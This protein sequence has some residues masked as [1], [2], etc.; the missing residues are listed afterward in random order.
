MRALRLSRYT[1]LGDGSLGIRWEDMKGK[2]ITNKNV[3]LH[4]Y[5]DIHPFRN[6]PVFNC[7]N[8]FIHRCNENFVGY[9]LKNTT[10]PFVKTVF[11]GSH[12]CENYTLIT[13]DGKYFDR[14]I[15]SKFDNIYLHEKYAR[16]KHRWW[17]NIDNIKII[18][19]S[20]YEKEINKFERESEP[21][22]FK[23]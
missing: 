6:G 2:V 23:E 8:L 4:E 5:G 7:E 1:S 20:D 9:W 13:D 21:I 10:F 19:S 14:K 12:P 16:Y 3:I 15:I 18:T 11:I 17:P 22:L